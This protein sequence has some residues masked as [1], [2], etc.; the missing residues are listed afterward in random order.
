MTPSQ[1]YELLTTY[2][3]PDRRW[4]IPLRTIQHRCSLPNPPPINKTRRKGGGRKPTLDPEQE[5][6]IVQRIIDD[7]KKKRAVPNHVLRLAIG[8][9]TG[10]GI[11]SH[12]QTQRFRRRNKYD[13]KNHE[14]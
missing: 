3:D 8:K 12:G 7:A 2:P 4:D 5:R 6:K 11:A 13:F 1:I 9:A 10:K 14:N